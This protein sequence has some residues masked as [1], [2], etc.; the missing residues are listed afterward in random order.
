M[1][2]E[3]GTRLGPYEIVAPVGAGGMGEVYRAR[4]VR[5][6]RT[7]AIKVLTGAFAADS[8]A[9]QRF[10]QEA[11]AIAALSD[12]HICTIHDVGRHG[13]LDYLVLEYLEGET[14]A[15]RLRRS[16][17]LPIEEA[18]AIAIQIGDA[19]HRAHRAGIVHRDL[20]P[21]NVMLVRR[22]G[23]SGA[24]DVKLL[25]FGVAAR[26][27][28]A[29][30]QALDSS[31]TST[32][33]ASS[34]KTSAAAVPAAAGLG[35]T[36]Q[37]MTPEQFD[38]ETGDHRVDIF[39][40]G[41]VLYEMLAG[42]KAFEGANALTVIA[43][44]KNSEPPPIA[45]LQSAHP[46]SLLDHVLRRCLEKDRERRWQ[47]IGDVTG[48][49]RWI[50]DQPIPPLIALASAAP[51]AATSR[52][53]MTR[54]RGVALAVALLLATIAAVV[55]MRALR[56][57]GPAADPPS[58]RF[59][60]ATAPTDDPSIALSPDGTQIAFVANQDRVPVLWIRA[61]DA[62]ENRT[63]PGTEGASAPFWSPDGRTIG[64][65][66][67][68]KLKRID[69]AGGTPLVIA[70]VPNARGGAW[71]SDGVI[72]FVPGVTAPITRVP[73]RGGAAERVTQV[74]SGSGPSHRL[75]QFLPDGKRF[76]FSSTL[77]TADTNGVYLGSLDKTPPVRLLPDDT[78][79]RFAAP[80]KLLTI[81]QGV[82]Q[83]YTFDAAAGVVRG[84]PIVIAQGFAGA[85]AATANGAF[86]TSDTGVLA[87]RV[88]T[89]QRRQLTWVNRQ[90]VVL[91][92]I[93]EPQTDFIASPELSADEQ[94]VVVFLQRTGDND[95]WVIELARNLA[96]RVT[97]GPPADSH[98]LWDPDGQH[99]V[100]SSRRFGGG[101]P[102]RQAIN[103]GKAE[104]LFANG[105]PGL[106][107]SWTHDRRYLLIRREG[108]N[109]GAD[110]VAVTT[111]G[112]RR[113]IVVAQSRSDETEGQFSPDGRW[114]AFVSNDSGQPEVFVQSFPEA[115]ARTQVSTAGGTQVRWSADGNELF[116]VAPNGKMMA[117]PV[118]L[119]GATP[120]VKLPVPL[121]QT[122]LATGTNVL[123]SKPQYAVARDGRFLLNTVI[124]SVSAP[125][126]VSVNWMKTK[127]APRQP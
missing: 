77:G 26:T 87:Y 52:T 96:H 18:L 65:F 84:E 66:A 24:P 110:L 103:G 56:G 2:L 13:D 116:Y 47:N 90:G 86:A 36:V 58:L 82:L 119:G 73:A 44:I 114:V 34:V 94:S 95:I 91:R 74:N 70:D 11:R 64:F 31:L 122:H 69:I 113:E 76:L 25:D 27:A 109:S 30:P 57:C 4:D 39:A 78:G 111:E 101:G 79:G 92:A 72:L 81:R 88:G 125:I 98:P 75:P 53:R 93:G 61:L 21:G 117:V 60:I 48:E 120:D 37:Y 106:A 3:A 22:S 71:N 68:D 46:P 123:G 29:T 51:V 124:D 102:A 97:D 16:P 9:R 83:A 89:A 63:L 115:R 100:F 38:G 33:T 105:E 10:E 62:I 99:V 20:K 5:L 50:A 54:V 6:D 1:A 35:G 7:V 42:R 55:A 85:G 107:L 43:A 23:A 112:E 15:D 40:F 104:P 118:T 127:S 126:V 14:L 28:V 80:D 17:V 121:F 32:M 67:G 108:A 59:E 41:C 12:P 49:L 8:E 19:L 45:A